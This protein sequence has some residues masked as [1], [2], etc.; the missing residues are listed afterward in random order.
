MKDNF[1]VRLILILLAA[2]ILF[3]LIHQYTVNS[4]GSSSPAVIQP[5]RSPRPATSTTER[6]VAPVNAAISLK[7]V[8][9]EDSVKT[10]NEVLPSEP[11]SNE[12]YRAVFEESPTTE[13][14][15]QYPRDRI[16]SVEELLPK[17]AANSKWAQVNPAGQGDVKDQNFLTAGFHIGID[18]VGNH[19]RN[20]NLSLRSEPPNPRI[21]GITPWMMSTIEPDVTR[22]HFEIGEH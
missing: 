4:K 1:A 18:T 16:T 6:F 10:I 21:E 14:A 22:R 17:D 12:Q 20:P 9:S 13:L 5:Q 7:P 19:L 2:A 15:S 8:I 3:V 11:E